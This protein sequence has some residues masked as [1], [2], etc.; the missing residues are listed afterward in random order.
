MKMSK[1]LLFVAAMLMAPLALAIPITSGSALDPAGDTT[2]ACCDLTSISAV[3]DD[4]GM[5][6]LSARFD[7]GGFD[8]ALAHASFM[9]D[10]DQ[11]PSTGHPGVANDGSID[12]AIL[13]VDYLVWT[14]GGSTAGQVLEMTGFNTA[15]SVGSVVTTY[16]ADGF[17]T[18]VPLT[19]LGGDDGLLDL[20]VV[21]SECVTPGAGAG[22]GN[23]GIA[24]I[25]TD[26]GLAPLSTYAVPA[27]GGWALMG[28]GLAGLSLVRRKTR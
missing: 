1:V 4:L 10:T 26:A 5:L 2:A 6:T 27:P 12:G 19:L 22:C 28:L 8:P 23:F 16:L 13:G 21:S 24:D 11:D 9:I 3:V 7:L 14:G 17:D 20:K 18:V 15:T 25:A